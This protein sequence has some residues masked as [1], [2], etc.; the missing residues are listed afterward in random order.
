MGEITSTLPSDIHGHWLFLYLQ[1][2][3][4]LPPIWYLDLWPFNYQYCLISDPVIAEQVQTRPK[5]P[6]LADF[7]VNLTGKRN[8]V[9]LEGE[10]W[11]MWRGR[12]NP[13]FAQ[14]H[15]MSLVGVIV[16]ETGLFCDVLERHANGENV[17]RL[18][19][20]LTALTVD[21][22]GRVTL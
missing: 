20:A 16:E 3:H 14:G 15:L 9:V 22:I 17:F 12:F 11:K 1:R 19:R 10:Q 4:S 8:L 13:G 5:H 21:V 18:E 2:T 7:L 6:V